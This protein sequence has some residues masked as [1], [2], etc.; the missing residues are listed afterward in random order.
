MNEPMKRNEFV[1]RATEKGCELN[2]EESNLIFIKSYYLRM[3]YLYALKKM[4]GATW[5]KCCKKAI[6]KLRRTGISVLETETC[7]HTQTYVL[8]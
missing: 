2:T 4:N 5:E 7:F 6:Q 1:N 8:N 3:A